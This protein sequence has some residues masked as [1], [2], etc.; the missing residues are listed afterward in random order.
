MRYIELGKKLFEYYFNEEKNG[1]PVI[2]YVDNDV[3]NHIY[4]S[5]H[6]HKHFQKLLISRNLFQITTNGK[7][8]MHPTIIDVCS[9]FY[10][11][12]ENESISIYNGNKSNRIQLKR[13][14]LNKNP[15][16]Y[17]PYIILLIYTYQQ[18]KTS[19]NASEYEHIYNLLLK[20]KEFLNDKQ[21]GQIPLHN[22]LP[23]NLFNIYSG[24]H[25]YSGCFK[26]H[27]PFTKQQ[28]E[29]VYKI[30]NKNGIYH[31][32][33]DNGTMDLLFK[34]ILDSRFKGRFEIGYRQ[35]NNV[36]TGIYKIPQKNILKN[37]TGENHEYVDFT[38]IPAFYWNGEKIIYLLRIH[39]FNSL[40]NEVLITI[41]DKEHLI[42]HTS[43]Y[44]YS[45]V[46]VS[47]WPKE[48]LAKNL[49]IDFIRPFNMF[50]I[51]VRF[52]QIW[53]EEIYREEFIANE[54]NC[55][56]NINYFIS[57]EAVKKPLDKL[58]GHDSNGNWEQLDDNFYYSL[59]SKMRIIIKNDCF[60]HTSLATSTSAI[61]L[62]DNG[63]YIEKYRGRISYLFYLLPKIDILKQ[64]NEKCF[65]Q[66][67][68]NEPV[69]IGANIFD[70][71]SIQNL[72]GGQNIRLFIINDENEIV[73]NKSIDLILERDQIPLNPVN[74]NPSNTIRIG[75]LLKEEVYED[76]SFLNKDYL[77]RILYS[78]SG[79]SLEKF[80]LNK[81]QIYK[82]IDEICIKIGKLE[83]IQKRTEKKQVFRNLIALGYIKESDIKGIY[84]VRNLALIQVNRKPNPNPN[85]RNNFQYIFR[86][87]GARNLPFVKKLIKEIRELGVRVEYKKK[88][89]DSVISSLMP[90]EIYFLFKDLNQYQEFLKQPNSKFLTTIPYEKNSCLISNISNSIELFRNN[91]G[92]EIYHDVFDEK[93]L[94]LILDGSIKLFKFINGQGEYGQDRYFIFEENRY[95]ETQKKEWAII[96]VLTKNSIPIIYSRYLGARGGDHNELYI[97]CPTTNVL[98]K[99]SNH[100][101]LPIEY[102]TDL[103]YLSGSVPISKSI[104]GENM[105]FETENSLDSKGKLEDV[106]KSTSFLMFKN[107]DRSTREL[108][109]E[110]LNSKIGYIQF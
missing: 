93:N 25:R 14:N 76:L 99:E 90:F 53:S 63:F 67:E 4:K 77:S 86:L 92:F 18:G 106:T 66:L 83:F 52:N 54:Y 65:Y 72:K 2:L 16:Y 50:Y 43:G 6:G 61:K 20:L 19:I 105:I 91:N 108:L 45:E 96:Y 44:C 102:Y 74:K 17:F 68:T 64:D 110:K 94:T 38:V 55:P 57:N 30:K 60:T 85:P 78:L 75:Y 107:I 49:K 80:K 79:Y 103:I 62:L 40:L 84:K 109:A 28:L 48:I 82:I 73:I 12:N 29:E 15:S 98:Y 27:V 58:K 23:I 59:C 71:N 97:I 1:E 56:E 39:S 33:T 9:K 41:D 104:N 3:L 87:S 35:I 69:E 13:D 36:I 101:I 10:N 88:N 26:F 42:Y 8:E 37:D 46:K 7:T 70:L 100:D 81:K 32:I 47:E 34:E 95:I 89:E 31:E 24:T 21:I 22:N 11:L 51:P 5:E